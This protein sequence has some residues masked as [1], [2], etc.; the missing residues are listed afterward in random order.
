V[1]GGGEVVYPVEPAAGVFAPVDGIIESL[2]DLGEDA[3]GVLFVVAVL[4]S[5]VEQQQARP[6]VTFEVGAEGL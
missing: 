1:A 3:V 6:L 2:E 5:A 4:G